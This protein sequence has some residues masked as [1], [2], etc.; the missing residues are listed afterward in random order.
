MWISISFLHTKYLFVD[1]D[2][3]A[4]EKKVSFHKVI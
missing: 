3:N 4:Q 1:I 2:K